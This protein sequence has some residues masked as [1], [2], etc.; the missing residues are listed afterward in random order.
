[1]PEEKG[2]EISVPKDLGQVA[3]S[4]KKFASFLEE[5]FNRNHFHS[6]FL[7]D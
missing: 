2:S 4:K 1:M 5:M 3:S 7:C 6:S